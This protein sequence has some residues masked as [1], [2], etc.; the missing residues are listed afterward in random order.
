M[1]Q[2]IKNIKVLSLLIIS[3][4]I[5]VFI[6]YI[7]KIR[8]LEYES[9]PSFG[10]LDEYSWVWQGI[11]IRKEGVPVGWSIF[12]GI[13]PGKN[14]VGLVQDFSIRINNKKIT[15]KNFGEF[16]KPT[17][18]VQELDY[19]LGIRQVTFVFPFFDHPPLGGLLM[20][21]GVPTTANT[22]TDISLKDVRFISLIMAIIVSILIYILAYQL[23]FSPIVSTLAVIVYSTVPSYLLASRFA[24]LENMLAPFALIQIIFLIA[25]NHFKT[26]K[27]L[28][29][30]FLTLSGISAGLMILIK[31]SGAGFIIGSI[32]LLFIWRFNFKLVV[33]IFI[34]P[35]IV[36]IATYLLWALQFSP[37]VLFQILQLQST[38]G[39]IGSLNF[40]SILPSL[41]FENF[42]LDGWWTWGFISFAL[43]GLKEGRKY[44]PILIPSFC[45]LLLVLFLGSSNYPWYYLS[46]IPFLAIFTA[47]EIYSIYKSPN[48]AIILSFILIPLSSSLYW[49]YG[50]LHQPLNIW[51]YRIFF[52]VCISAASVRIIKPQSLA[53]RIAWISF[54]LIIFVLIVKWNINSLYFI[55][56]NFGKLPFPS[57]PTL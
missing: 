10:I 7:D 22:F 12:Y 39:F 13:D 35:T 24:L 4:A 44:A 28:S 49:G 23:T 36:I 29:L 2:K 54:C 6:F 32:I 41:R 3:V 25:A 30:T 14:N 26:A 55:I 33:S 17:V 20:S 47:L 43:I 37:A 45:H 27:R 21:L 9:V 42:P 51:A 48:F 5:I 11:S 18:A 57:L 1:I 38:R 52:L 16:P 56:S 34:F 31:E 53:S 50:V 8:Q 40:L 15:S 46:L 19:G